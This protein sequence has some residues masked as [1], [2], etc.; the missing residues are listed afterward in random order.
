M[1]AN[2]VIQAEDAIW[3][4]IGEEIVVIRGDGKSAHVLN[5]TA[6]LI[7][8]RCDGR[9]SIDEIAADLCECFDVSREEACADVKEI[10]EK[11][12]QLRAISRKGGGQS[13]QFLYL[14]M[15]DMR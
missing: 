7:W 4:R 15:G 10:I 13:G 2:N 8:E 9:R 11:L 12:T 3:R 5:K 6:A 1:M 14:S